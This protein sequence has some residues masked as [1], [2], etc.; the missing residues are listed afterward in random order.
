MLLAVVANARGRYT[1]SGRGRHPA[2]ARPLGVRGE[3]VTTD[4]GE[5]EM[6]R[7]SVE[8]VSGVMFSGKSEELIRRVRRALIA[9]KRVQ[10]FK[11]IL[12]DRHGGVQRIG[13]HDGRW[14][15]AVPVH[16]AVQVIEGLH[17]ATEVVAIDEVQ[18][19]DAGI[20]AVA[21]HLADSGV[22]VILAGT[23]MDF[24]GDPFGPVPEL[25][26]VADRV[27]KLQAICVVCGGLATRNQRL[28]DGQP[29]P[30]EGPTILVGGAQRYEARCRR[31]HTVPAIDRDQTRF[32]TDPPE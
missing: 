21:N 19:L 25:L 4:S 12:D 1:L 32:L 29:A 2:A 5:Q 7:G 31:C 3:P 17:R 16:R 23:D 22:R 20:V 14:I 15:E 30:A 10:V 27:D 9:R 13:T 24:R 11:S 8:V 6:Q 18:F 28:I 26:A